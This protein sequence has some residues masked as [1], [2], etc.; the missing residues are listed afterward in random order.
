LG[1]GIKD[2]T[3]IDV[4]LENA[5]AKNIER[6]ELMLEKLNKQIG[7]ELTIA[8]I[9]KL[10]GKKHPSRIDIAHKIVNLGFANSTWEAYEFFIGYKTKNYIP[11]EKLNAEKSIDLIFSSGG[12]PVLAHPYDTRIEKGKYFDDEEVNKEKSRLQ[13]FG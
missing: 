3:T 11:T 13:N 12:I 10:S 1:Y 8:D 4:E 6:Y 5:R 2:G 7:T 9:L